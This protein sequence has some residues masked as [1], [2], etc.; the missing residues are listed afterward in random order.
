MPLSGSKQR[1]L[2]GFFAWGGCRVW[3]AR[4]FEGA[5]RTQVGMGRHG[6]GVLRR[7]ILIGIVEEGAHFFDA[8]CDKGARLREIVGREMDV[9]RGIGLQIHISQVQIG[10]RDAPLRGRI[11]RVH[12]ELMAVRCALAPGFPV[13]NEDA[14]AIANRHVEHDPNL[15]LAQREI[16][17][18]LDAEVVLGQHGLQCGVR[19]G[20]KKGLETRRNALDRLHLVRCQKGFAVIVFKQIGISGWGTP[21]ML[22]LGIPKVLV[23]Q[24]LRV[25]LH[26]LRGNPAS[27]LQR[28]EHLPDGLVD[29]SSDEL[30]NRGHFFEAIEQ[31]GLRVCV[32]LPTVPTAVVIKI[33]LP[34]A[35]LKHAVPRG[36]PGK[37]VLENGHENRGRGDGY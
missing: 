12:R 5:G 13:E 18:F 6:K 2:G 25:G 34:L 11:Q 14:F 31:L 20:R 32:L 36:G 23:E 3:V 9:A 7:G 16:G 30:G 28:L 4:G 8:L 22:L 37:F 29:H 15:G 10:K 27:H 21:P 1:E 19:I 35:G 24:I 33:I 17:E 26:S